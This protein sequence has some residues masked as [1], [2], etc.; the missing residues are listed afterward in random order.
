MYSHSLTSALSVLILFAWTVSCEDLIRSEQLGRIFADS[1]E[2]YTAQLKSQAALAQ[3]DLNT[4]IN[5]RNQNRSVSGTCSTVTY[6]YLSYKQ[7]MLSLSDRV[8]L[9][10]PATLE[11]L[12]AE[13]ISLRLEE[14]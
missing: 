14:L 7:S 10:S 11:S 3:W 5:E 6:M 13:C 9:S 4:N 8:L 12:G 1:S 2:N